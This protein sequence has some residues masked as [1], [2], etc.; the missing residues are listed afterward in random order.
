MLQEKSRIIKIIVT[1]HFKK[2]NRKSVCFYNVLRFYETA[3]VI[4]Y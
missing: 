3:K 4:K 2:Q 1:L